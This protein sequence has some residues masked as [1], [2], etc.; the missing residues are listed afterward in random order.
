[1]TLIRKNQL[2]RSSTLLRESIISINK[3]F[4]LTKG[5]ADSSAA[6]SAS[7]FKPFGFGGGLQPAAQPKPLFG[8]AASLPTGASPASQTANN[9]NEENEDG[10]N[11]NQN[12][13]DYEPQVDFKPLVKL[14]EVEVKT[15]EEDEDVLFKARCKL[16]RFIAET[17]EWKEKGAGEIKVLKRKETTNVFR[18]LMRRDQIFKLC[19]NHRITSDIK[20]E[21]VNEKQ[22]RWHAQD[23]SEPGEGKHEL[24]TAKFRHDDEAKQFKAEVEKAQV[25]LASEPSIPQ[26]DTNKATAV[27]TPTATSSGA[28]SKTSLSEM[29]KKDKQWTCNA[30][31]VSNGDNLLKCLACQAVRTDGKTPTG[32]LP[33]SESEDSGID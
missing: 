13:E 25:I 28:G 2:I 30:C 19:A 17:K 1:M 4:F 26:T 14:E 9:N 16:Y 23:Y 33:K 18:I 29:F 7:I 6:A 10:G 24:L 31:Y 3:T 15:G 8:G 20:L 32:T 22:V 11:E 12:P 5:N 27:K 21:I